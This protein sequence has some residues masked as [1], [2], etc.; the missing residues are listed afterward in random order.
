MTHRLQ[1]VKLTSMRESNGA[2]GVYE[3][4]F[5]FS[6]AVTRPEILNNRRRV[7]TSAVT[8]TDYR[9][10]GRPS[11]WSAMVDS[12]AADTPAE[13]SHPRLFILS[14]GNIFDR[15]HWQTYPSS[16]S[17][18]QIHDPAQAW[19]ALTVGAC[20]HKTTIEET[21]FQPLAAEGELSPFTS[22]STMWD[23]VWPLKPDV[24]F[25]GGNA[26]SNGEFTDNFASLEILTAEA[27]H[28]RRLFSTTNATSAAS[29]L[30][31]RIAAEL[32]AQF[33]G[34]RPETI[35]GL[36]THSARWTEQMLKIYPPD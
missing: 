34:L 25:E 2:G 21:D 1:S 32:M 8:A 22:T 9:D 28:H 27:F 4:A 17:V 24:V 12:L 7:F 3:H 26:A 16:L 31:A 11:A 33:P 36:M 18:N 19:N 10:F 29:A 13:P 5:L 6:E 23:S 15:N 30:A 35:R 20:T 14:A